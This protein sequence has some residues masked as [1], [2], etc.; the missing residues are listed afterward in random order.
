MINKR[1]QCLIL[2][3]NRHWKS[4]KLLL[5]ASVS[6][7]VAQSEL[8]RYTEPSPVQKASNLPWGTHCICWAR[9]NADPTDRV[10]FASF[11]PNPTPNALHILKVTVTGG[12]YQSKHQNRKKKKIPLWDMVR[13]IGFKTLQ[14]VTWVI[15]MWS[16][17]SKHTPTWIMMLLALSGKGKKKQHLAARTME[18]IS[19]W[20]IQ[21]LFGQVNCVFF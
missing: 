12:P 6:V 19:V 14:N 21:V 1:R 15:L 16:Q 10:A 7:S 4:K 5:I 9:V 8:L 11:R 18:E 17:N 20:V 3:I 2:Q 13:H